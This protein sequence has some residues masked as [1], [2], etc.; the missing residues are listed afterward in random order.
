MGSKPLSVETRQSLKRKKAISTRTYTLDSS[1]S[2]VYKTLIESFTKTDFETYEYY[3]KKWGS[4]GRKRP[5]LIEA[6]ENRQVAGPP[7]ELAKLR[8]DSSYTHQKVWQCIRYR[9]TNLYS[10]H[11]T[12]VNST[13]DAV[14]AK[15]AR[16]VFS[17]MQEFPRLHSSEWGNTKDEVIK[18]LVIC[19]KQKFDSQDN[20]CAISKVPL[21]LAIGTDVGNKCSIDR[22]DSAKPYTEKN[23]HLVTFWAN[24]MKLDTPLDQFLERINLIH[25]ANYA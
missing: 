5:A 2:T 4:P 12:R 16:G 19:F 23:I 1:V 18:S 25:K 17:R 21:E 6:M 11:Q 14:W 10:Y 20:L 3:Y 13:Q 8:L 7:L 24:V 15:L 22:I 9:W